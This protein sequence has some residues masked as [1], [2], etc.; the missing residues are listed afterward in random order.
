MRLAE[1][2]T[3]LEGLSD[4]K[5]THYVT[6]EIYFE[7]VLS[8]TSKSEEV[9]FPKQLK[10]RHKDQITKEQEKHNPFAKKLQTAMI[11]KRAPSGW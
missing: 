8:G 2:S 5:Y 10:L 3:K 9:N 1:F 4:L 11:F 7:R 6:H